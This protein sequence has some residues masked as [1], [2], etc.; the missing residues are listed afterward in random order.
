MA[1]PSIDRSSF[2]IQLM[3]F[4]G[5]Q[6]VN[7]GRC[8]VALTK[9]DYTH[10]RLYNCVLVNSMIPGGVNRAIAMDGKPL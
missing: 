9:A 6:F 8:D 3:L 7:G 1:G 5:A 2:Q 10:R 4:G